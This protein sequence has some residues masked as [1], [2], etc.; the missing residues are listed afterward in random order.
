MI[1]SNQG[2][3]IRRAGLR[4]LTHPTPPHALSPT[5]S[6]GLMAKAT[7][8][9]KDRRGA[10]AV[11]FALTLP[12][13]IGG[14]GLG[15]EVSNWYMTERGMQ[16]AADAGALAAAINGG[17]NFD[18]EAKA[19]AARY[20]FTDGVNNASVTVRGPPNGTG[21]A[22]P[23]GG[24]TCYSV[25][26]SGKVPLYLSP[27]VG[28]AGN[29][30][31]QQNLG[32]TAIAALATTQRAYCILALGAN[33]VEG[34]TSNGA[35]QADLSGC[36]IK[37]NTTATCSGSDLNADVGDTVG[38]NNGCGVKR[39]SGLLPTPDPFSG[40]ASNIPPDTCPGSVYPQELP[41]PLPASNLWTGSQNLSGNFQ[42]CGDLKLT[43][44]VTIN[45]AS[46][47]VLV[48]QNGRLDTNGH[49][50]QT[51]NG[52]TLTVVFSG[53]I[54]GTQV[55][56]PVGTGT[57]SIVAPTT[58]PWSGFALYQDP[59][60]TSGPG[61][62]ITLSSAE[63]DISGIIY[64]PHSRFTFS[65]GGNGGNGQRCFVM[66]VDTLRIN[67]TGSILSANDCQDA[68]FARPTGAVPNGRGQL[69]S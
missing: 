47:A 62:D 8:F 18:V 66:V 58:G 16:N 46:G 20:G 69:A 61:M 11:L 29:G 68:T 5:V 42:V 22:C 12:M 1:T 53:T 60:L 65:G 26:V 28:Y 34:I 59:K 36:N 44:N 24:N 51:A 25:T 49:S 64:I 7:R 10:A 37:S 13:L 43:S 40:V 35:P 9:P 6:S 31:G 52:S 2:P 30:Q 48:I 50:F 56:A 57:I 33:G 32:A 3:R 19:V 39:A 63:W 67:G 55:H 23:G 45:A 4:S 14:L 27:V 17:S 41:G 54:G 38:A 21:A 15:F